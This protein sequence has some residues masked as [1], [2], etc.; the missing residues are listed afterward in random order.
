MSLVE[1]FDRLM[2]YVRY[3]CYH[4]PHRRRPPPPHMFGFCSV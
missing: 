2:K 3:D 1:F 4:H